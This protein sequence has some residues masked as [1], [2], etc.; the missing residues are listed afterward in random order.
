M[1]ANAIQKTFAFDREATFADQTAKNW[2]ALTANGSTF[3]CFDLAYEEVG[4][5]PPL[6]LNRVWLKTSLVLVE[7]V[8]C[9]KI[10]PEQL[11]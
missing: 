4:Q 7:L 5:V 10:V 11:P 8:D 1:V 2:D 6:R 9:S 3:Y